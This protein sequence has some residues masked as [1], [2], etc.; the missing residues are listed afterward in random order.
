M[1]GMTILGGRAVL[2]HFW[3]TAEWRSEEDV[4]TYVVGRGR[5]AAGA[6]R[7]AGGWKRVATDVVGSH[8]AFSDEAVAARPL[9]LRSDAP[10]AAMPGTGGKNIYLFGGVALGLQVERVVPPV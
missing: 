9:T 5:R 4:W 8:V 1:A 2:T 3:G 7:P 10:A 6:A